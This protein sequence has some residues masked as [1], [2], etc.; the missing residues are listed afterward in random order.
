[1]AD[2]QEPE[3]IRRQMQVQRAAL[4]Q[5]LDRL[6]NRIVQTV[7]GAREAVAETIQTVKESVQSSVETVRDTVQTSVDNVKETLDV[8]RQVERHPWGMI[9]GSIAVGFA[10]GWLTNRAAR[11]ARPPAPPWSYAPPPYPH[12]TRRFE[13]GLRPAT[14][15]TG[16]PATSRPESAPAPPPPRSWVNDLAEKFAPEIQK[17]KGL[18]IGAGLGLL[19][20]VVGQ[21]VPDQLRPR[22]TEIMNDITTKLGGEPLKGDLLEGLLPEHHNGHHRT[23]EEVSA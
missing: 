12:A 22:V 3:V 8:K 1:M 23:R 7:E 10:I 17:A 2:E 4:D 5:K 21:A 13:E 14:E 15:F 9:G 16:A 18:A 19:R 11:N 20:E 6:E